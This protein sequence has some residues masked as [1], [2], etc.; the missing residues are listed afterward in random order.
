MRKRVKT[1]ENALNVIK[2]GR[3]FTIKTKLRSTCH[4]KQPYIC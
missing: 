4:E 1:S 3:Y 2:S